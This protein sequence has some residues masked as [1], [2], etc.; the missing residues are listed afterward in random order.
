MKLQDLFAHFILAQ[1][2]MYPTAR[3]VSENNQRAVSQSLL[4]IEVSDIT[5]NHRQVLPGSVFVAI[6]GTK[7]D[8]HNFLNEAIRAHAIA[9]V[10]Q[11]V[12]QVPVEFEGYVLVV[13]DTR[14]ALAHLAARFFAEPSKELFL[15]GVT[16]TNGKTSSTFFIEHMLNHV[17]HR[18]GVIGTICHRLGSKTWETSLTTP[19]AVSLN[20]RLRE[21][22]T[23]GATAVAME[24]SSH[25]IEQKRTASLAFNVALFTNL[26]QDH[27]DFHRE[28]TAYFLT[29]ENLFKEGLG[30]STKFPKFAVINT[31]SRW[32][33]MIRIDPLSE[34]LTY[35]TQGSDLVYRIENESWGKTH[36]GISMGSGFFHLE[37]PMIGSFN[38]AN[39]VGAT[40]VGLIAGM[41]ISQISAAFRDFPGVPG[42]MQIVPNSIGRKVLVDYAHSP[43]ALEN[44]L[45]SL[46]RLRKKEKANYKI[47]VVFGC[48]GDRDKGKRPLMGK[49]A[50]ALADFIW[51]TS[52]NP[53]TEDPQKIIEDI[54]Y[55]MSPGH[56]QI[57]IEIDRK[58][59]IQKAL[60]SST[61]G[62]LVLIA[63]KGHENYQI[64][65]QEKIHFSDFE[66]VQNFLSS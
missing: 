46:L 44:V 39:A 26:T 32:G 34:V 14:L 43:D 38:V 3:D 53:R 10:V 50:E 6:K 18:T 12:S 42:R 37:I 30:A 61:S 9:L 40:A 55:G 66:C 22:R 21:M 15:V 16:G 4:Q 28:M 58:K 17:R 36:F 20:R 48:G 11:D 49:I 27:L 63:G 65:G 29:K 7:H 59:A 19:D 45:H 51:L 33:R 47:H 31:D 56:Q 5:Q 60:E 13:R 2:S 41:S 1:R 25:A 57:Q 35:G 23:E 54:L 64:I 52:D 24:V 8:G 62:D